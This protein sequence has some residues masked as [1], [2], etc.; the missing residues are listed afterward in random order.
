MVFDN[1]LQHYVAPLELGVVLE[2][3]YWTKKKA[4]ME[5]EITRTNVQLALDEL[6][7]HGRDVFNEYAP[8]MRAACQERLQWCPER[9]EYETCKA[10]ILS[11]QLIY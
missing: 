6:S 1:V 4:N 7:L 9:T 2:I 3:P 11:S 8:L 5:L 10:F